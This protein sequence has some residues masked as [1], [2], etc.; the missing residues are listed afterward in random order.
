[1]KDEYVSD[2]K[3]HLP[4]YGVGPFYGAGIISLTVIGIVLSC[5]G[6]F[7]F[8]KFQGTKIPF[9]LVG[10]FICL[11]GFLVW[12]KA[13]F[14]IDRYIE[15]NELCTDGIYGIVRNPCYS[16]IMLMCSGALLIA[17][18]VALLLLPLLYWLAMTVLMKN[19][20]EKWLYQ[21]YGEQY[22]EYCRQVN[23]CIPW[24]RK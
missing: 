18:N 5:L 24:F 19:T 22:Q 2:N 12:F 3:K 21:L 17:N 13:A 20:E 15:H 7:D 9:I 6:V 23:R 1:M 10:I 8:A 4:I 11:G 14:R 16:G